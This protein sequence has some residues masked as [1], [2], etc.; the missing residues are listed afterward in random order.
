META[1]TDVYNLMT[2]IQ[3]DDEDMT[4]EKFAELMNTWLT[5]KANEKETWGSD[6]LEWAK[7]NG[8]MAGDS[9]GRMMPNKILYQIRK[10]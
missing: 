7:T 9:A 1:R 6:N 4:D 5:N 10:Q 2:N 3:E 8:I